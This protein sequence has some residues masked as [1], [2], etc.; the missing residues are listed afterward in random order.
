M[1]NYS[2]LTK[3]FAKQ[4]EKGNWNKEDVP[5]QLQPDVYAILQEN[6]KTETEVGEE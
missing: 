3:L 1:E 6:E 4:I 2:S 5:S